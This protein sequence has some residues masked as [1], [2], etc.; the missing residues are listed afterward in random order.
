[1]SR[2]LHIHLPDPRPTHHP[3]AAA[4]RPPMAAPGTGSGGD[5]SA[6]RPRLD[7]I[8]AGSTSG[9]L[10]G[11]GAVLDPRVGDPGPAG[12]VA[13]GSGRGAHTLAAALAVQGIAM[14]PRTVRQYLDLRELVTGVPMPRGGTD[15]IRHGAQARAELAELKK[16]DAGTLQLFHLDAAGCAP[17]LPPTSTGCRPGHRGHLPYA[18]LQGRRGHVMAALAA[19]G[20]TPQLAGTIHAACRRLRQDLAPS[21]PPMP[22]AESL[23]AKGQAKR[24]SMRCSRARRI[25][26]SVVAGS[27]S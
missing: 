15:R 24:R 27:S 5:V 14:R 6:L 25:Q 4:P 21:Y 23:C 26:V 11:P 13:T 8:P 16:A 3:V 17:T 22:S 18:H 9:G 7:R 12:A 19:P 2:P 1:M 10:S 20:T